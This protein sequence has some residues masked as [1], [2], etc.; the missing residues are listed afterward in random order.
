MQDTKSIGWGTGQNIENM[1]LVIMFT[2]LTLNANGLGDAQKWASLLTELPRAD[3]ICLQEMHLVFERQFTFQLH[4]QG[5][6]YYY[7]NGTMAS[8]GVCILVKHNISVQVKMVGLI[9]GHLVVLDLTGPFGTR[10]LICIYAPSQSKERI[11]FFESMQGFFTKDMIVLGDFNSVM[12]SLD[13]LSKKLEK[14]STQLE[15]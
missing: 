8:A 12:S 13:R 3:V 11:S 10:T 7:S 9:P 4:A 6:D 14:T 2:V 15:C 5:Y 1:N